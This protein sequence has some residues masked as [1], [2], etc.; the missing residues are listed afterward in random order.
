MTECCF[1]FT[2]KYRSPFD[3]LLLWLFPSVYPPP[4]GLL[5]LS[6]RSSIYYFHPPC[7][8]S[9]TLPQSV[10]ILS[11]LW[12]TH[13]FCFFLF[14]LV[15]CDTFL[16]SGSIIP[17]LSYL[18]VS[19][20]LH[21]VHPCIFCCFICNPVQAIIHRFIFLWPSYECMLFYFLSST[22]TSVISSVTHGFRTSSLILYPSVCSA[23]LI[24][25]THTHTHTLHFNSHFSRWT[26]VSQLPP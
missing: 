20:I 15:N 21:I 23:A 22:I 19:P 5:F 10:T 13:T 11:S 24:T 17:G 25:H 2:E 4:C 12:R 9:C 6:Y 7:R 3:I 14:L 8:C 26:W 1:K 16:Y 18:N